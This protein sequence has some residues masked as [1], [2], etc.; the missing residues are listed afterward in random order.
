MYESQVNRLTDELAVLRKKISSER[1][2]LAS[3]T[4]KVTKAV[5]ALSK[6][7]PSQLKQRGNDLER[8][9]RE[10]ARIEGKLGDLEK[11]YSSKQ[12]SLTSARANL[13]RARRAQQQKDD[14]EA[15]KRRRADL[16]HIR[17]MEQ[18]R[19]SALLMPALEVRAPLV[20]APRDAPFDETF[21]ICL[22]FAGEQRDYVERIAR[23]LKA[24][25]FKVFYDKDDEIAA[26]LWGRDLGEVLDYVYREG[27][28]FCLMF[29]SEDYARKSWTRHE[30]RSALA[31]ALNEE[32][33]YV[34]PAR[35]DDTE[36]PGLRPTIGYLDLRETAPA[37]LIDFV[38]ERLSNP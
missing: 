9:Q 5:E 31:R 18:S 19:R 1:T 4:G 13:D 15:E 2:R 32:D 33:G 11:Q 37:T 3:A 8:S 36:L 14:R 28:R 22:S 38:A 26:K 25:G 35:F 21:D 17:R 10:F 16:D 29:I 24:R 6:A 20:A 23:E 12:K 30:R 34:L 7:T 27:S